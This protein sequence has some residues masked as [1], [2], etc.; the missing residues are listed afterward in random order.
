[1]ADLVQWKTKSNRKPLIIKGAHQTGKTWLMKAFGA[2]YYENTAY[3]SFYQNPRMHR[4]FEQ[5][6]SIEQLMLILE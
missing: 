4:L 5:G 2:A 1:M 6:Y 3:I